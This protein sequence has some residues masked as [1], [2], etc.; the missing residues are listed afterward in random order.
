MPDGRLPAPDGPPGGAGA[1]IADIV[2]Y[3]NPRVAYD[4]AVYSRRYRLPP[5]RLQV[6]SSGG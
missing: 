3:A 6:L 2:P 1:T 5:A 4:L